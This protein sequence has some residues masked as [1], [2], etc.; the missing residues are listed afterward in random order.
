MWSKEIILT[1]I[2]SLSLR[3]LCYSHISNGHLRARELHELKARNYVNESTLADSYDFIIAGG[4][5]AGLV[6]A[7]RLS[8]DSNITVLVL[9]AGLSGDDK[10]ENINPPSGAYFNSLGG[11]DY[12]WHQKTIP[13]SKIGNRVV[14]WPRGKVLGGCTATNGNYYVRPPQIEIDAWKNMQGSEDGADAWSWDK[15]DAAMKK[16]ETFTPPET[17]VQNTGKIQFTAGSFGSQGP[18]HVSYPG[19]MFAV[20]GDWLPSLEAAGIPSTSDPAGGSNIGGFVSTLSINPT[21]WTRSYSK[22]AYIDPLPPRKN[23]D[24]LTSAYVTRIVWGD[25]SS[26]GDQVATGVEFQSTAAGP[27]KTVKVNKEVILAAGVLGSAQILMFSGVGPTDVLSAVNINVTV[28]LPGVGQHLADHLAVPVAWESKVENAGDLHATGSDFSKEARTLSFVNSAVAYV[29]GSAIFDNV[30]EFEATI[31]GAYDASV[32]NLPSQSSEVIAGYKAIYAESQKLLSSNVG[33]I[34]LLLSINSPGRI[35][36]QAAIQHPYSQGRM[37][38]NSTSPFDPLVID[39]QY[40]AHPSDVA[41]IRQ[42]IKLAR[43]VGQS[44]PI[45]NS[46]GAELAPGPDVQTD[47]QIET[48]VTNVASTEY[49]PSGS[50]AMLPKSQGGV[51]NPKLQVFGL[52]NVRVA[53]ASVYPFALSA[54]LAAPTYGLAEIA[55]Q[56]L[57]AQYS[58]TSNGNS[59][60]T[61]GTNGNSNTDGGSNTGTNSASTILMSSSGFW[62]AIL[63][64]TGTLAYASF[65]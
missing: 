14:T 49:H 62:T 44:A 7:S 1:T 27:K 35:I 54:H 59:S 22:S 30:T 31:S 38:I 36:I 17:D 55:S 53:D 48:Y 8:E 24:I 3:V 15:F 45:N 16:A 56:I 28:D 41:I 19:F 50:C 52:A 58:N 46:L 13:Q 20:V 26:S 42:G 37:Y 2:A 64:L 34:E 29:N 32:S 60:N 33:Q 47:E 21:N 25:K 6:I 63:G 65:L 12:D 57:L 61:N 4:G 43:K 10:A 39:P 18:L 23:L 40:F 9:E 11:T 51:V 5:Q